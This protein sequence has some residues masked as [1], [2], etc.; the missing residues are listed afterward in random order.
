MTD[1]RGSA[2]LLGAAIAAVILLVGMMAVTA[3]GVMS[4]A[5]H[6]RTAAEAAALAAVSPVVR[7]P[8]AA[9]RGVAA[10]NLA[11]LVH[12]SCPP[13]GAPPPTRSRVWV[14]TEVDVPFFGTLVIPAE[15]AAEYSVEGR[16]HG[17]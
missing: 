13:P 2:S 4:A 10:L 7:D 11:R 9:A 8:V 17:W 3:A 6:A 14:E 15:A 1:E 16:E 12:C 5:Y